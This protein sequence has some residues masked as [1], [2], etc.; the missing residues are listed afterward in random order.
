MQY[1]TGKSRDETWRGVALVEQQGA[2]RSSR[3]VRHYQ[4]NSHDTCSGVSTSLFQKFFLRLMQIQSTKDWICT[5]E[6]YCFFVVHHVGT[7]TA[8]H[9]HHDALDTSYVYCRDVSAWQAKWN[10]G[11]CELVST[12]LLDHMWT[13]WS[14]KKTVDFVGWFSALNSELTGRHSMSQ[15]LY[16]VVVANKSDAG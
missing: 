5:R 16:L 2:T 1:G 9:A 3:H 7:S 13:L 12:I 4:R 10:V 15:L 8:W 14:E 6:H 11:F